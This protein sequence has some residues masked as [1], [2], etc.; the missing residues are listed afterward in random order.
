MKWIV[1]ALCAALSGCTL[2]ESQQQPPP[3]VNAILN[4]AYQGGPVKMVMDRNGAP[5]RQMSVQG[6]MVYSWEQDR[7][8]YSQTLPPAQTHCQM[9]AYVNSQGIVT[10]MVANGQMAACTAFLR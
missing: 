6:G 5:L 3:D 8:M 7:T 9:D 1:F 10:E 2:M 4:S